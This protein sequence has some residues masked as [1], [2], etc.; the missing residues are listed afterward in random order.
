MGLEFIDLGD[1]VQTALQHHLESLD[2]G[3]TKANI[4]AKGA[5]IAE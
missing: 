2:K 3:V 1:R 5:T 4:T